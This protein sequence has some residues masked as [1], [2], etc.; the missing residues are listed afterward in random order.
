MLRDTPCLRGLVDNRS[1]MSGNTI[2]L[3][4]YPRRVF[5]HCGCEQP[6]QPCQP[7]H[8]GAAGGRDRPL[9]LPARRNRGRPA[10]ACRKR[11][12]TFWDKKQ[13][14]V[15]TPT[16]EQTSRIKVEFEHS[17]QEEFEIL[18]KLRTLPTDGV[19]EPE[20]DRRTRKN[21]QYVCERCGVADSET[22]WKN[23]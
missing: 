8:Q 7:P 21:P 20:S 16:L 19:G 9:P 13:V 1:R 17:T 4:N 3:K 11:Q 14:F 5:G 10:I 18:P 6:G 15:S 2:L 22:H 23:R 12:T